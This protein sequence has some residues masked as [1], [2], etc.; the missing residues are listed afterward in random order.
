MYPRI[1]WRRPSQRETAQDCGPRGMR[2]FGSREAGQACGVDTLAR[3][4]PEAWGIMPCMGLP[5]ARDLLGRPVDT[6][7]CASLCP[8]TLIR[9]PRGARKS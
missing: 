7:S 6:T 2:V 3:S 1:E 4:G 8:T 9:V 5:H